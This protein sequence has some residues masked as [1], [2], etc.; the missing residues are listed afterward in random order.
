MKFVLLLVLI[1]FSSLLQQQ[2]D[3]KEPEPVGPKV[4]LGQGAAIFDD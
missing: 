3:T 2:T 1:A 4:H